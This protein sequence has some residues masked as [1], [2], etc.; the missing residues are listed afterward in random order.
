MQSQTSTTGHLNSQRGDAEDILQG[1]P[2]GKEAVNCWGLGVAESE[3]EKVQGAPGMRGPHSVVI[4]LQELNQI[5]TGNIREK[6][7]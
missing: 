1:P 5:P 7:P 3:S 6:S 4:Y 2:P